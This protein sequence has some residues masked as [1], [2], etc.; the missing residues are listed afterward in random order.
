MVCDPGLHIVL[1][2][3]TDQKFWSKLHFY[4]FKDVSSAHQLQLFDPNP[5]DPLW[6]VIIF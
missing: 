5:Y 3:T 1:T 2:T 6:N 4:V